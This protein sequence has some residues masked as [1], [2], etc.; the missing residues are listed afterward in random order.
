MQKITML[1]SYV[2]KD[3]MEDYSD[4]F[5]V[6]ATKLANDGISLLS[7]INLMKEKNED[8]IASFSKEIKKHR[9]FLIQLSDKYEGVSL[10]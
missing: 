1:L 9:D 5:L 6:E 10:S 4:E 2:T 7:E 8:K 3:N